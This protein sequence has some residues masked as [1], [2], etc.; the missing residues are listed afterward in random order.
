[1]GAGDPSRRGAYNGRPSS[2]IRFGLMRLAIG[3][4]TLMLIGGCRRKAAPQET[5]ATTASITPTPP[6]PSSSAKA[7]KAWEGK[8]LHLWTTACDTSALEVTDV[9][10]RIASRPGLV[11]SVGVACTA[12]ARDGGLVT[13]AERPLGKGRGQVVGN[14]AKSGVITSL[15]FANPGPGGFDGPLGMAVIGDE[16]ARARLVNEIVNAATRDNARAVELD[17]EAMPTEAGANYVTLAR[18]VIARLPGVEVAIDVHPKTVDDPG[19][20]GPGSH[21]YAALAD[22][23]A[24]VR[25]MTYDLSIGPVPPGPS[26]RASWVRDVV[27]YARSKGVPPSKLE[28]GLPAYGYD[29]PETG[30][31]APVPLRYEEVMALLKR[32]KAT[33]ARD[34]NGS[35]HF[36]Y[37]GQQVWF[38]DAESIGRLLADLAD[39][40][41]HV[42]GLAIWGIGRADPNLGKVLGAAGF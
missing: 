14:L 23:G 15:V 42:R 19:W 20:D 12:I 27:N 41:P 13:H 2:G 9:L 34:E 30:K 25:L 8:R 24:I 4:V 36:E 32:V 40:A 39:V 31:G 28:I 21:D 22:A 26:T 37:A 7:A 29:F 35:P 33:V 16:K 6:I 10:A 3:F 5:A 38:D 11:D 1:M 17:L 18:E